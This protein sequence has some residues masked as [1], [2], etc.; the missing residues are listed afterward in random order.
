MPSK[1]LELYLGDYLSLFDVHDCKGRD[2]LGDCN[3][4]LL[5]YLDDDDLVWSHNNN[6]ADRVGYYPVVVKGSKAYIV[7]SPTAFEALLGC[8]TLD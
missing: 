1:D 2:D 3:D 6:D 4:D 5:E 8:G 7:P